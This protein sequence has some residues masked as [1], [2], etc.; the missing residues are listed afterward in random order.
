[1]WESERHFIQPFELKHLNCCNT[2]FLNLIPFVQGRE[3][4]ARCTS[5][6]TWTR[7][8]WWQWSR[9]QCRRKT[10]GRSRASA[11]R[12]ESSRRS[13]IGTS[14]S[15]TASRSTTWA[16]STIHHVSYITLLYSIY[17]MW[18]NITIHHVSYITFTIFTTWATLLFTMWAKLCTYVLCKVQW[19][20]AEV[21]V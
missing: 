7:E 8:R 1:M 15:S 17:T 21:W 6:V 3:G 20:S 5:A 16:N 13:L 2:R 4:S 14:Y 9:S 11:T 10:R 19:V 12:S 18:A